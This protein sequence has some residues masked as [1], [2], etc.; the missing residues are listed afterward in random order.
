[1]KTPD[2]VLQLLEELTDEAED[3]SVVT[4]DTSYALIT[5]GERPDPI[6]LSA[7]ECELL[8]HSENTVERLFDAL[9]APSASIEL[10]H[11]RLSTDAE[12]ALTQLF[13]D[14]S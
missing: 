4:V 6:R 8:L 2:R 7:P 3:T 10:Y 9:G 13:D 12:T 14:V 5:V 11:V 1:M